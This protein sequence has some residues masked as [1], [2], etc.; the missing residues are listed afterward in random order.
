MQMGYNTGAYRRVENKQHINLASNLVSLFND[1]CSIWYGCS[2]E[3]SEMTRTT[4]VHGPPSVVLRGC[5]Y[6]I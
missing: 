6:Q 2:R 1:V 5:D 3:V 4:Y